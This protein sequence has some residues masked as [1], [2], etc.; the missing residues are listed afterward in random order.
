MKILR[1]GVTGCAGRTAVRP[2]PR[3]AIA[4]GVGV[5]LVSAIAAAEEG[6]DP[7]QM[8]IPEALIEDI[9]PSDLEIGDEEEVSSSGQEQEADEEPGQGAA[10]ASPSGPEPRF[11]RQPTQVDPTHRASSL[12]DQG[13]VHLQAGDAQDAARA[14]KRALDLDPELHAARHGYVRILVATGRVERARE[15]LRA[16]IEYAPDHEPTVRAYAELAE[17]LGDRG[18]A[19]AA[20]RQ[21]R[22]SKDGMS[23]AAEGQLAVLYLRAG[24]HSE[25]KERYERLVDREPGNPR[26][27]LGRAISQELSGE[28]GQALES[29]R[30]VLDMDGLDEETTDYAEGRIRALEAYLDER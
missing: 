29:W 6:A 20:L 12:Y 1:N 16:G 7:T 26:W 8:P 13:R 17:Q 24:A 10:D 15:L 27:L 4:T 2:M 14:F 23:T 5:L 25:G 30:R 11:Q 21:L 22:D 18:S 19:I 28:G 9:D 3:L